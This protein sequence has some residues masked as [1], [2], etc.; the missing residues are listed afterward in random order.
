MAVSLSAKPGRDG[1]EGLLWGPSFPTAD[2]AGYLLDEDEEEFLTEGPCSPLSS[3]SSYAAD[4]FPSSPLSSLSPPPSPPPPPLLGCK[5]GADLLSLPWL[6]ADELP[7]GHL[8]AGSSN[9]DAFSGMDWMAEKMD[10]SEFD[11]DCLMGPCAPDPNP[12]SAE[13]LMASLEP[14]PNPDGL[15]FPPAAPEEE[16]GLALPHLPVLPEPQAEPEIK[17]EPPSPV[18][19]LSLLPPLSP[20]CTLD[21]GSEVDVAESKKPAPAPAEKV[22][23]PRLVLS[24]AASSNIVLLLPPKEEPFPVPAPAPATPPGPACSE[25][26]SDLGSQPPTPPPPP[27]A[28]GSSRTKPYPSPSPSPSQPGAAPAPAALTGRV[29]SAGAPKVVEK[30][31]KKMEQNKTAATRY[32]QKKRAEHEALGSQ[33][34]ELEQ[35][36]RE[37]AQKAESISKEIQYLKD[38]IEEVRNAK[39]R[40]AQA[41]QS[42]A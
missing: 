30:K 19:S 11:L 37:L 7:Y 20:A 40:K 17:S 24:L 22:L 10:L 12:D 13:D 36:N 14:L 6:S 5:A 26:E 29:K 1:T 41:P 28:S 25:S 38:L 27:R 16:L 9:E 15:L 34:A 2:P 23:V 21:L 18:P 42:D 39:S 3:S 35:R 31:L 32:R 33:C 4:T 8:S